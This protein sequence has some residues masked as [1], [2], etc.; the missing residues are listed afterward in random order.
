MITVYKISSPSTEK[1]YIGQTTK[2]IRQRLY[3]HRTDFKNYTLGKRNYRSSFEIL[4][5]GN[6][7]IESLE[8][9]IKENKSACERKHI[10]EN[11]SVNIVNR[12]AYQNC[13]ES[14]TF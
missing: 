10:L 13:Q 2:Q 9:T 5:F 11:N 1:C 6:A 4:K 12:H 3:E 14:L 8:E 7:I